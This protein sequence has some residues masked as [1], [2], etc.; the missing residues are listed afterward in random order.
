MG[1]QL[2]DHYIVTGQTLDGYAYDTC[3]NALCD[4]PD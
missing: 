4:G 2:V 3:G 1:D